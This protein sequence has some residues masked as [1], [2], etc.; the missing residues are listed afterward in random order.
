MGELSRTDAERLLVDYRNALEEVAKGN[1][2]SPTFRELAWAVQRFGIPLHVFDELLR[3][4]ATD[5]SVSRFG[6]WAELEPYCQRVA[7]SVGEMCT[8]VFGVREPAQLSKAIEHAR[9]LGVAMQLTN[10]LR[11]VGEDARRGRV[12]LPEDELERFGLSVTSVLDMSAI[13]KPGWRPFLGFQLE[14]A[15]AYY[16]GAA[17]GYALLDGSG[18]AAARACGIGYEGILDRID[19]SAGDV[20]SRRARLGW[21]ARLAVLARAIAP[22]S[23]AG[24]AAGPA[25]LARHPSSTVPPA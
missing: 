22:A 12:Y 11:D 24:R 3:G 1:G 20:F 14:R 13:D 23:H 21:G 16:R 9:T 5:L 2:K 10:I 8:Y 25:L 18:A 17:P 15:R 19:A 4:V 7:S 6:S